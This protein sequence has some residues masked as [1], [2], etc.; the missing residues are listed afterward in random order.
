M[1]WNAASLTEGIELSRYDIIVA[2]SALIKENRD[3]TAIP[4]GR[5]LALHSRAAIFLRP[6][7]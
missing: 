7:K 4:S 6:G 2:Q 3:Q 5:S 1:A